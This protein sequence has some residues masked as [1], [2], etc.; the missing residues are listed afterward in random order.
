[1]ILGPIPKPKPKGKPKPKPKPHKLNDGN[2][3][4]TDWDVEIDNWA[5]SPIEVFGY[6]D[7]EDFAPLADQDL[8]LEDSRIMTVYNGCIQSIS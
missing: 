4:Y 1:M 2:E 8:V 7:G 3:F 6:V 5:E